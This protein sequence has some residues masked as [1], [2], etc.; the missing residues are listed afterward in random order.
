MTMHPALAELI[1]LL[2]LKPVSA[3]LF[4]GQNESKG[5]PRLFGGQILAQALKAA[6]L[7]VEK[8]RLIHSVHAYFLRLG[9]NRKPVMYEVDRLRDGRS[10]ATRS[11][12]ATQSGEIIFKATVSFHIQEQGL[13]HQ[14]DCDRYP[15]PESMEDDV[16]IAQRLDSARTKAI[17][18]ALRERAFE[19]RSLYPMNKPPPDQPIKP[20]WIR[21]RSPLEDDPLLHQCLLAYATDM[22]LMSTALVPHLK[23]YRRGT[24]QGASLDHA[25]WFHRAF[26]ADRW[27]MYDRE[28]PVASAGRGFNRGLIYHSSGQL[29]VSTMQESLMRV[30]DRP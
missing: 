16:A 7:T 4:Q 13:V 14:I 11:V 20:A 17:P 26:R 12:K 6:A 29:V 18:W 24:F 30:R 15:P 22:G 28:S 2:Q 10:F 21:T 5:G 9:S 3:G 27:L 19:V 25:I 23:Q 1:E 8:T